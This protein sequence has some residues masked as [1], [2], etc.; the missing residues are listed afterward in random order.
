MNLNLWIYYAIY[1][2]LAIALLLLYTA[3][4]KN[5]GEKITSVLLIMSAV[6][7]LSSTSF[8]IKL[9][10][11][12]D[13][14]TNRVYGMVGLNVL[15]CAVCGFYLAITRRLVTAFAG[16]ILALDWLYWAMLFPS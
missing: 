11:S 4:R 15:L 7:L 13:G 14:Y 8:G 16:I 2:W 3:W 6:F 5:A 12:R 1:V 10:L 9:V